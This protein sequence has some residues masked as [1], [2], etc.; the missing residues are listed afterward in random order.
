[1]GKRLGVFAVL[2]ALVLGVFAIGGGT[3]LASGTT[4]YVNASTG[5][6]GN[7][8]LSAG[9]P[10]KTIQSAIDKASS[11]DTIVVAAGTYTENVTVNKSLTI[12][13][14][15]AGVDAR[16][17]STGSESTVD[18]NGGPNFTVTASNVTIDG[19][20][21]LGPSN[22]GSAA[23]VMQ[24]TYSGETIQNNI[25][26]NPGRAASFETSDTVFR[27]NHVHGV[28]SPG[29]GF[30]ENSTNV[31]N[32]T[33]AD[34]LFDGAANS[35]ADI[36]II[37][38]S[39]MSTGIVVSGNQ[40]VNSDTLIAL[41]YT[42]GAQITDNVITGAG[43]SAIYIGGGSTNITVS[44][45]S[46]TGGTAKAINVAND[47]GDGANSSITITG[48]TLK[49]NA[50][51]IYVGATALSGTIE[52]HTNA[53]AGNTQF[54]V[55]NYSDN[56]VD[57]ANN[58]WGSA[59]GPYYDNPNLPDACGLNT[60][61]PHGKGNGVTPCVKFAPWLGMPT[62]GHTYSWS[63]GTNEL[64]VNART[65]QFTFLYQTSSGGLAVCGDSHALTF[66]LA[67]NTGVLIFATCSE[68]PNQRI[69]VIGST[70]GGVLVTLATKSGN[71]PWQW[72]GSSYR[73]KSVS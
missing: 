12:D 65:H 69:T 72:Q 41:F 34:N 48:N 26:Q 27:Q 55:A 57:A 46:V 21:L 53:I 70:N 67:N 25:I 63:D 3:A 10:C 42:N 35:N 52:A 18:G 16:T 49:N 73:L 43:G 37:S 38:S 23:I 1:M 24:G 2:V 32:V 29:D 64:F 51:G 36:T 33:L 66:R 6:A 56:L 47:F 9:S 60:N 54:G 4:Y 68:N 40:S 39:A 31:S 58:W 14:A 19:F 45:N 50:Y 11:G 13:G 44:G 59:S 7:D 22:Q 15:Q 62:P 30:Q 28:G 8:C 20:T 5:S 61:N 71:Q 17:R